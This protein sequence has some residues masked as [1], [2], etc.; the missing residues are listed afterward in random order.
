MCKKDIDIYL[1]P[2]SGYFWQTIDFEAQSTCRVFI[3]TYS[4][5]K[6]KFDLE[7]FP[8]SVTKFC[9]NS[10]HVQGWEAW[11]NKVI[12]K[13]IYVKKNIIWRECLML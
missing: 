2:P 4:I 9:S 11:V 13:P 3:Q 1:T 10:Q 5:L 6:F 8:L 12:E 7:E